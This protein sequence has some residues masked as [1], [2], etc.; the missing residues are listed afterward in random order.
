MFKKKNKLN[1]YEPF[2]F[3]KKKG[4][5]MR[6]LG[7]GYSIVFIVN[8][9]TLIVL[10]FYMYLLSSLGFKRTRALTDPDFALLTN[11]Y[12][13]AKYFFM[14]LVPMFMV[15][16]VPMALFIRLVVVSLLD[17][18]NLYWSSYF[19]PDDENARINYSRSN[20]DEADQKLM[21]TLSADQRNNTKDT[22]VILKY[23]HIILTVVAL[24]FVIVSFVLFCIDISDC[25]RATNGAYSLC[26]DLRFCCATDVRP[27]PG[28]TAGCPWIQ[29]CS[30]ISPPV[31][32]D[33]LD[34][35]PYFDWA[36]GMTIV[37]MVLLIVHLL[38]G[39]LVKFSN[40]DEEEGGG[41]T[42]SSKN[43]GYEMAAKMNTGNSKKQSPFTTLGG[44]L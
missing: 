26:S 34:H 1:K 5:S 19:D 43:K 33:S 2:F 24:I 31:T 7:A 27:A 20:S 36:F 44:D 3:W 28:I 40:E 11:D 41:S 21:T 16:L 37:V 10:F 35:D 22:L 32:T 13:G 8:V 6:T 23:A 4:N 39:I 42:T 29:S 12:A 25:N 15:F 14:S 30:S 38:V 18:L 17:T 9:L